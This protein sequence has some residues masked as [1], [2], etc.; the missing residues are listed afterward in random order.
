MTTITTKAIVGKDGKLQLNDALALPTTGE[1]DVAI[2][3]ATEEEPYD[4]EAL[5][6]FLKEVAEKGTFKNGPDP[7]EWQTEIREDRPIS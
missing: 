1:V 2:T 4:G 3:I 6:A 5:V 7:S